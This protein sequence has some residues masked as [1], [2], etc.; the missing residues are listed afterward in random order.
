MVKNLPLKDDVARHLA[1]A[2]YA[3]EEGIIDI[4][5]VTAPVGED[6]PTEPIKLIEVNR[7]TIPMGIVLVYFGPGEN[8]PYP[9]V[10]IAL[11]RQELTLPNGWRIGPRLEPRLGNN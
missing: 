2:H 3:L 10:I 11:G 4:Y 9:S 8:I 1:D 7:Q 5:R 6:H